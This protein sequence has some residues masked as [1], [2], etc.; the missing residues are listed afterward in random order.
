M[1]TSLHDT[2]TP[3]ENPISEEGYSKDLSRRHVQMIAVGGAIGTGLFLGAGARLQVAGPSLAIIYAICGLC[4]FMVLRATGELVMY[5][6]SSGGF[7]TYAREFLGEW[8][9]YSVGWFFFLNWAMSGIVDI[10]AAALYMHYWPFFA[11]MPQWMMALCALVLVGVVNLA[12][13]R[14]FGE[15]EFWFSLVKVM[16]LATFLVVGAGVLFSHH[17]L[18]GF[19]PGLH[20]ITENGG[21]FPHGI[22]APLFMTQGVVFA[23]AAVE[24]I[25]VAAGEC[26]DAHKIVPRAI[27]SVIWRIVLFYVGSIVL[28]VCILPW[29]AYSSN[30]SPFVTFLSKLGVPGAAGI[31]NFVVLTAALSSLN[32][33]LYSTGRILRA[34]AVGG[35]G[36]RIMA[37]L[38]RNQ[39]PYIGICSTLFIYLIGVGLNYFIPT[40]VFE[41]VLSISSLGILGTWACILL[42]QI[43][44][45]RSINKGEIVPTSFPMPGAPYTGYLTLAF[46]L[47]VLVLMAFDYPAGTYAVSGIPV[48]AAIFV[49]GWFWFHPEA[50]RN[51][52][53]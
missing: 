50:Q 49:A 13:V 23:Y 39:V 21:I 27:N 38:N 37:R 18:G 2:Q 20:L 52:E 43:R 17:H 36:P 1:T 33:G 15:I 42:C 32:S 48:L 29:S 35:S 47:A 8:A 53:K 40:Q 51:R 22:I 9:A 45:R 19:T 12:G 3:P 30:V 44:L 16:T 25:G 10:T 41:I 28:L 34:L 24:L 11:D 6:P 46:L 4:A 14:Y 31:M 26:H 5:R 7:V